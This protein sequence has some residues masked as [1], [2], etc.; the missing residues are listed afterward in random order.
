MRKPN[1]FDVF[2]NGNFIVSKP[3]VINGN[4]YVTGD[5]LFKNS[6]RLEVFG[7]VIVNKSILDGSIIVH[8]NLICNEICNINVEVDENI[9]IDDDANF[10]ILASTNGHISIGGSAYG[11]R[12]STEGGS[13]KIGGTADLTYIYAFDEIDIG[14]Y[15]IAKSIAAGN[16]LTL[17][18]S[19]INSFSL[20]KLKVSIY[21]GGLHSKNLNID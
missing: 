3:L 14:E 16:G 18:G 9:F 6:A 12:L 7:D 10:L 17:G 1:K 21:K 5:I 15:V 20:G 4:L 8:G 19:I 11:I 2:S 13:I